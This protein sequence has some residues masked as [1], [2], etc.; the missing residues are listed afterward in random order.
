ML[1]LIGHCS[2][3]AEILTHSS[4]PSQWFF[5]FLQ[6]YVM[7]LFFNST[8]VVIGI[9][10]CLLARIPF[11]CY[12]TTLCFSVIPLKFLSRPCHLQVRS[13]GPTVKHLQVCCC[14]SRHVTSPFLKQFKIFSWRSETH[15]SKKRMWG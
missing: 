7:C 12:W 8:A 9:N 1:L 4:A 5:F 3:C 15:R 6:F 14:C 10:R 2:T 11:N 13:S